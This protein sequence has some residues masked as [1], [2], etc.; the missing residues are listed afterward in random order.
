MPNQVVQSKWKERDREKE[1]VL[2]KGR[3]AAAEAEDARN[4]IEHWTKGSRCYLVVSSGKNG[5]LF[6]TVDFGDTQHAHPTLN[7]K[8]LFVLS[9]PNSKIIIKVKD[10]RKKK[11]LIREIPDRL[12]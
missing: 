3:S 9:K 1:S 5:F 6:S 2:L 12:D 8:E 10:V 7:C 11:G 4:A